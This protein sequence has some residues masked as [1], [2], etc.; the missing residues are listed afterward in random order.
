ML[1]LF[2]SLSYGC[3]KSEFGPK[4]QAVKKAPE[5]F[6]DYWFF[7]K[8]S[9]W[10]YK[11]KGSSP[12]VYDTVTTAG[13]PKADYFEPYEQI[14]PYF[15]SGPCEMYYQYM[16]L[17]SNSTYFP[18][19][20]RSEGREILSSE[21]FGDRWVVNQIWDTKG[22]ATEDFLFTYPLQVGVKPG[23]CEYWAADTHAVVTPTYVFPKSVT[24]VAPDSTEYRS[25]RVSFSKEAGISYRRLYNGQEWELVNYRVKR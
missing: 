3:S 20:D 4:C 14:P 16:L 13:I 8:D 6:L 17:H 12:A 5:E 11:L 1:L 22:L 25:V 18:R 19:R 24:F 23:C 2:I 7:P 10:V 15:Y 21:S 9:W